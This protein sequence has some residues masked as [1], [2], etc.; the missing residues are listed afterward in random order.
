M[1]YL[2]TGLS[3][4]RPHNGKKKK[5]KELDYLKHFFPFWINVT[6]ICM[7]RKKGVNFS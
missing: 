5:K 6:I 4:L 3:H 1:I 7:E 2:L